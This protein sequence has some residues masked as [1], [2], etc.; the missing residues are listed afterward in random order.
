M[1][2]TPSRCCVP[3]LPPTPRPQAAF[4]APATEEQRACVELLGR[5]NADIT[6]RA[7]QLMAA[8]DAEQVG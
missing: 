5:I 8:G 6:Q 4:P 1:H 3:A 7:V 2:R